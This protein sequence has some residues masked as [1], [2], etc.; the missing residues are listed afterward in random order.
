[1]L[2]CLVICEENFKNFRKETMPFVK[3]ISRGKDEKEHVFDCHG[4]HLICREW[5]GLVVTV[6]KAW[7]VSSIYSLKIFEEIPMGL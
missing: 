4:I 2:I 3:T 7:S 1:M 6:K 5:W